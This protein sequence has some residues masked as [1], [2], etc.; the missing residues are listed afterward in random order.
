[1]CG[2]DQGIGA[3]SA[4]VDWLFGQYVQTAA[5][6]LNSLCGMQTRGASNDHQIHRV[7]RQECEQI[8]KG[9]AAVL[10]AQARDLAGICAVD[11]GDF[12]S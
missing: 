10:L 2:L 6:R 5:G 11:R 8:L 7:M 4:D 9:A 12:D 1:M 3:L